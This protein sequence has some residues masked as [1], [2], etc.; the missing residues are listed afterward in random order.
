MKFKSTVTLLIGGLML[1]AIPAMAH[2]SFMAEFDQSQPVTLDGVVTA[3]KWQN[4]HTFFDVAV[5]DQNG[6]KVKWVLETGSPNSL[7]VR[8]WTKETLKPGDHVFVRGY[9]ARTDPKL[10]A[11][12]SVTLPDGRTI[13]GGQMDDGGPTQ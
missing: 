10:A 12:R 4:P 11:A 3:I 8:N 7:R 2:H 13:F 6:K 1:T 9:R 5:T